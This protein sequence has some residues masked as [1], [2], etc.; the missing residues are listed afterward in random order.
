MDIFT[1]AII[2]MENSFQFKDPNG[3]V[4]VVCSC[5]VYRDGF[6]V[7]GWRLW[8]VKNEIKSTAFLTAEDG[9][10]MCARTML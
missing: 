6:H 7:T 8:H 3:E 1:Q 2:T 10:V 5:I 9:N 4:L